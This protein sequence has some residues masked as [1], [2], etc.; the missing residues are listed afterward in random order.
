MASYSENQKI[1]KILVFP[2]VFLKIRC[3][4][5]VLWQIAGELL[6]LSRAG[7]ENNLKNND[8]KVFVCS[9]IAEE[10]TKSVIAFVC[11]CISYIRNCILRELVIFPRK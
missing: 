8:S 4:G 10:I 3:F 11:L 9:Q 2:Y 5:W 6:A 1:V 7:E